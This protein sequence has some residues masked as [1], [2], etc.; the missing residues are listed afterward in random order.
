MTI[1]VNQSE[2]YIKEHIL[3]FDKDG[4]LK[5]RE[6]VNLEYKESFSFSNASKYAKTMAAFA[7][8][9]CLLGSAR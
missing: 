7:N 2:K 6:R 5:C 8:N 1:D 4:K 9:I 3:I